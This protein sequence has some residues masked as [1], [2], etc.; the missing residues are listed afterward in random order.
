VILQVDHVSYAFRNRV[1]N[2]FA[3]Q[4]CDVLLYCFVD[5]SLDDYL[6]VNVSV[7][8]VLIGELDEPLELWVSHLSSAFGVHILRVVLWVGRVW[9]KHSAKSLLGLIC[10]R[11][12]ATEVLGAPREASSVAIA[13]DV[14]A[15][16]DDCLVE[17]TLERV[18]ILR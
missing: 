5:L 6:G 10:A 14:A 15:P 17:V 18:I 11:I 13:V 9:V 16:V 8:E 4:L 1:A 12:D 3:Q 2:G 7:G